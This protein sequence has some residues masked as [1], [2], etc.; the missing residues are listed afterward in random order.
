[1][2][3]LKQLTKPTQAM[4]RSTVVSLMP[5]GEAVAANRDGNPLGPAMVMAGALFGR[6]ALQL[7]GFGKPEKLEA[8]STNNP[9][10]HL[11]SFQTGSG[12]P[13]APSID[14]NGRLPPEVANGCDYNSS[15]TFGSLIN[16][17]DS[18]VT[19]PLPT[20]PS[21]DHEP[22]CALPV[23]SMRACTLTV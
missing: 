23:V 14:R 21:A 19:L 6:P 12:K 10:T 22:V 16:R 18:T 8:D 5:V 1:M 20:A 11:N 7:A 3:A 13:A 4:I 17:T 15:T 2:R 9:P